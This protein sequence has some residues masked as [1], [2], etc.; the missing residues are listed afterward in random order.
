MFVFNWNML[1]TS[2]KCFLLLNWKSGEEITE[3]GIQ[4]SKTYC[5]TLLLVVEDSGYNGHFLTTDHWVRQR[6][7]DKERLENFQRGRFRNAKPRCIGHSKST[8]NPAGDS[9]RNLSHN[10]RLP[11]VLAVN[12]LQKDNYYHIHVRWYN[13]WANKGKWETTNHSDCKIINWSVTG[14]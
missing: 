12:I 13:C 9:V 2:R 14:T 5:K 4:K 7:G 3:K 10:H 8:R 6:K 1:V 11:C